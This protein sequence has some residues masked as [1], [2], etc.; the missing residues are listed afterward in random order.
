MLRDGAPVAVPVKIGSSDGT[1]TAVTGELT[2]ERQ[3][4]RRLA[5]RIVRAEP[6]DAPLIAFRKVTKVYG[7]GDAEVRR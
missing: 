7:T 1:H 5:D 2:V 6:M 3:G 4:H